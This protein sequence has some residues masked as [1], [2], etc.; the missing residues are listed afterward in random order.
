MPTFNQIF[1]TQR[2]LQI[3]VVLSATLIMKLA[4]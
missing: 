3:V 1:S 2:L 4:S